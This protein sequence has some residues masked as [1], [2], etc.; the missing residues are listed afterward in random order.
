MKTI[1]RLLVVLTTLLASATLV[2]CK[3]TII[4]AD[5]L[6]SAAQAFLKEYFP[7]AAVSYAKKDRELSGTTYEVVLQDRTKIDFNAKGEWDTVKCKAAAVPSSLVPA[8]I[9]EYV[10]SQFPGQIIVKIDR[11]PYGHEIELGSDLELKFDK[12]GKLMTIDD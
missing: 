10:R 4:T 1:T 12:K 9:A 8:P 3:E 6:P 11:E 7:D 2:S 5:Q